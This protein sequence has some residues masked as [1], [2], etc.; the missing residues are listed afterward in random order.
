MYVSAYH[1]TNA[2][3]YLKI[4]ESKYGQ[5]NEQNLKKSHGDIQIFCS[6]IV[7]IKLVHPCINMLSGIE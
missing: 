1:P 3:R 6:Q 7:E 2:K 4:E 5:L